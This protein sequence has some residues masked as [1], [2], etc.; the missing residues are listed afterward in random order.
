M[1]Y[2]QIHTCTVLGA[3][4]PAVTVEVHLANGLPN[5]SL[6]GLADT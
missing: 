4:A 6:V 1:G 2:A 3:V 5:F